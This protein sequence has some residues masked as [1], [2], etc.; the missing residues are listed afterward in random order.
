LQATQVTYDLYHG[1]T[2]LD[3][4]GHKPAFA[5]GYGLSY[6]TFG[7]ENPNFVVEG[8]HIVASVDVTNTGERVGDVVVQFYV[9]F[10]NSAVDRPMK[11]LRGFKRVTLEPGETQTVR[12]L[13]Q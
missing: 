2:R 10:E 13:A 1:Y 9:G 4:A 7:L 12:L 3:K 5:F 11:L 8:D 6:T